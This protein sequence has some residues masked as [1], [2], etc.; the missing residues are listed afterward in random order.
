MACILGM[1]SRRPERPR[2]PKPTRPPSAK[3]CTGPD[4]WAS[5][6]RR[7]AAVEWEVF[8]SCPQCWGNSWVCGSPRLTPPGAS[9][10]P[11]DC[12]DGRAAVALLALNVG[13]GTRAKRALKRCLKLDGLGLVECV[14]VLLEVCAAIHPVFQTLM[15]PLWQLWL[16]RAVGSGERI[17]GATV[18]RQ[19]QRVS[20]G[21]YTPQADAGWPRSARLLKD[22]QPW[23]AFPVLPAR[24]VVVQFFNARFVERAATQRGAFDLKDAGV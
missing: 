15:K 1:R 20:L 3:C 21:G 16:C 8:M 2:A 12:D 6:K 14:C 19:G 7:R 24:A 11:V 9:T 4:G 23:R 5:A 13:I 22:E 18:D 17:E 10:S